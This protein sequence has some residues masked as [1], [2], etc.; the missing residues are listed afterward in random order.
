VFDPQIIGP[1]DPFYELPNTPRPDSLQNLKSLTPLQGH[2]SVIH[3]SSLFHLFDE[4][5][6]ITLAK[7]LASLLSSE[8]GSVICGC[9]RGAPVKTITSDLMGYTMVCHSPESWR[10]LWD[11]QIFGKGKVKVDAVITNTKRDDLHRETFYML[12]WSVTRL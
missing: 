9:H 2:V 8:P 12:Y 1:R 7:R 10:E 3:A 6:H 4:E 5:G 11:G